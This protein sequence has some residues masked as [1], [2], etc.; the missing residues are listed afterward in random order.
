MV[1]KQ[2]GNWPG[3]S[4]LL[5]SGFWE[6][7]TSLLVGTW[8]D[9]QCLA[10]K[11]IL[12]TWLLKIAGDYQRLL[13]LLRCE[14]PFFSAVTV[15]ISSANCAASSFCLKIVMPQNSHTVYRNRLYTS[16]KDPTPW[17]LQV[18]FPSMSVTGAQL[19]KQDC[20]SPLNPEIPTGLSHIIPPC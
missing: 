9:L 2:S 4:R 1:Q 19:L 14:L 17:Q 12:K 11:E 18:T 3:S 8:G 13:E 16:N 5:S 6:D 20:F 15:E 7:N 10:H